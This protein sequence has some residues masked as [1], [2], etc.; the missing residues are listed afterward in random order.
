MK[1]VTQNNLPVNL[2]RASKN[3]LGTKNFTYFVH[4]NDARRIANTE[5]KKN[6]E[7]KVHYFKLT[8]RN[9]KLI[10]MSDYNTVKEIRDG[11]PPHHTRGNQQIV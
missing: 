6:Y 4:G 1:I 8:N 11:A 7:N 3:S 5:Y 10:D 9:I 2:Y